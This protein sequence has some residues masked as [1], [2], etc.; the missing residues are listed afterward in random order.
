MK[1]YLFE[2][3]NVSGEKIAGSLE[4]EDMKQALELLKQQ[5]Y[6]PLRLE[7][8]RNVMDS[9][10]SV[11]DRV[12]VGEMAI[13]ARQ[14]AIMV[15]AGFPL[16]QA[17]KTSVNQTKNTK[18]KETLALIAMDLESGLS[19]SMSAAKHPEVFSRFIVNMVRSGEETGQLNKV[20]REVA[21]EIEKQKSLQSKINSVLMYPIFVVVMMIAAMVVVMV[22]VIP[23]LKALFDDVGA[24]LPLATRILIA[25]SDFF[26]NYWYLVIIGSVILIFGLY[27][28]FTSDYGR[29][30]R[31]KYI[32]KIP[33]VGH[34]ILMSSMMRF[35]RTFGMLVEGGIPILDAIEITA[36]VM[37]NS[38]FKKSIR[39]CSPYVEKGIP[40]STP[41]KRDQ[42]FPTVV[43]QMVAVGEQSG[44]LGKAM[45]NLST[46]FE[47]ETDMLV[48]GIFS[49]FEPIM[50]VVVGLGV[51]GLVF[52]VLLPV[53]QVSQVL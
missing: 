53:F 21:E 46:Y 38:V 8:Q 18:L 50:L 33:V 16:I 22:Y 1:T 45:S 10:L 49:L 51:A 20:L 15:E 3:K 13:F 5:K 26:I 4:A 32:L 41:L 37:D 39:D 9:L 24:Q 17:M 31:D 6:T 44:Q 19:L 48:K 30:W 12:S 34:L 52:A 47:E 2:A 35:S 25:L 29:A 7:K 23:Q 40:F 42:L 28:F 11:L 27:S 36:G 14:L 43:G